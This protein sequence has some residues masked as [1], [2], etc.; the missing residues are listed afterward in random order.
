MNL[1]GIKRT[2]FEIRHEGRGFRSFVQLRYSIDDSNKL[3]IDKVRANRRLELAL[4]KS[5]AFR[6]LEESVDKLQRQENP[7]VPAE[8]AVVTPVSVVAPAT[9]DLTAKPVTMKATIG[10]SGSGITKPIDETPVKVN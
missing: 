2:S 7:T 3:L 6:E 8:A 1:V 10:D 4:R 5:A 9:T